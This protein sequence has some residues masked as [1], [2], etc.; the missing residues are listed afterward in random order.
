VALF[1]R[2]QLRFVRPGA[3]VRAHPELLYE[4]ALSGAAQEG[5]GR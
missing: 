5:T 2:G 4:L 3:E 1:E